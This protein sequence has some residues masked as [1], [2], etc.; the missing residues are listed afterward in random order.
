M[1]FL[2][3]TSYSLTYYRYADG[4]YNSYWLG[5]LVNLLMTSGQKK[6]VERN[7]L[8][9]CVFLKWQDNVN[10]LDFFLES[11]ETTKPTFSVKYI[12]LRGQKKE[13]PVLLSKDKQFRLTMRWIT[14]LVQ[15]RKENYLSQRIYMELTSIKDPSRH[16]LVK[17]RDE[18]LSAAIVNRFNLRYAY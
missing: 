2:S 15:A 13:F 18:L 7:L 12:I 16:V 4:V 5:K 14:N 9:A 11:L 8:K 1:R 17:K 6:L 10:P 3:G